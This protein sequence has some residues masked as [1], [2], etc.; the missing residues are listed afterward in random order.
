MMFQNL[1]IHVPFCS[2]KCDYCAFY[3]L[4]N[5]ET[6][7]YLAYLD[8]LERELERRR[9]ELQNL[10]SVYFGGGTPTVLPPELL[11]RLYRMVFRTVSPAENAECT[12]EANPETVDS[13]RAEII[14]KYLNRVSMGV[15]S[16]LTEKRAVLGR[17]PDSAEHIYTAIEALEKQGVH[18]LGI[19]LIYAVPGEKMEN[20]IQDLTLAGQLPVKHISTYSLTPEE[21]TPYAEKYGLA[22]VDEDLSSLM[23]HKTA[24]LLSPRFER[25]EI[26]NLAIPGYEAKHN[27]NIWHGE[28]YLGLGPAASSFNGIDRWTEQS[29]LKRWLDGEEPEWDQIPVPDRQREILMM[30]LRTV[31]GWTREQ[32]LAASGGTEWLELAAE[33]LESLQR[34]K[35]LTVDRDVCR[36]TEKGLEFWNEI[37]YR[38]IR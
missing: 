1:Y 37:A 20:W 16:F 27:W 14:G 5:A 32:F 12:T 38:L 33:E 15:Q 8:H 21:R 19:D 28:T 17:K 24:E 35:L 11:E 10:K 18:N 26:S 36:P 4:A 2:R 29:S 22:S 3:S 13:E 30:G 9:P 7:Q 34:D 23:W 25:Y 31:K 6:K